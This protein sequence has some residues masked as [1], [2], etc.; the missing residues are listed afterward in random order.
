GFPSSVAMSLVL[1][2]R[3]PH[4]DLFLAELQPTTDMR[5]LVE[6]L[7]ARRPARLPGL[8]R[9]RASSGFRSWRG[10]VLG[11]EIERQAQVAALR[12]VPFR[13]L[14]RSVVSLSPKNT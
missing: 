14:C 6:N 5:A 9:L 3:Q 13:E 10:I 12:P 4:D 2:D 11:E 1:F 8:G 7:R